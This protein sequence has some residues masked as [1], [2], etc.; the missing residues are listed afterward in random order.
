[1]QMKKIIFG[2]VLTLSTAYSLTI[3]DLREIQGVNPTPNKLNNYIILKAKESNIPPIILK[4]ILLKEGL[5]NHKWKQY[6]PDR[7]Y[8]HD[9]IVYHPDSVGSYG[10]GLFQITYFL[11]NSNQENEIKKVVRDWKFNVDMAITKLL[12]KWKANVGSTT[13]VD[14]NPLI[15]ENWYYPIAWYNGS[16]AKAKEYV[17]IVYN[18]MRD[19]NKVVYALGSSQNRNTISSYYKTISNISDPYI[20]PSFRGDDIRGS[21]PQVYTLKDIVDSGG[22]LHIWNKN[23][24]SYS[25]YNLNG[26]STNTTDGVAGIFDGAGS[27]INPKGNGYGNNYDIAK[28]YPHG[29]TGSTVVFQWLYD[30][31]TCSQLDISSQYDIGD[32]VIKSKKWSEHLTEK[33][34]KVKLNEDA[35]ITMK[36]PD[37][38]PTWITFAVTTTSTLPYPNLIKAECKTSSDRFKTGIRSDI[39]KNLVDVTYDYYWTGTGSIISNVN[40]TFNPPYGMTADLASTFRTKNSLTSF[41]WLKQGDCQKLKISASDDSSVAVNGVHIKE[42][43][44]ENWGESKCSSL[45]CTLSPSTNDFFVIK[46]KSSP[47]A[48]TSGQIQAECVQ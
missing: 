39:D 36:R 38:N 10:L 27:L 35:P 21:R 46:V 37:S 26:E 40:R 41:Q 23:S 44:A 31:S 43:D 25:R 17:D 15:I 47:D 22:E 34:F 30:A 3:D 19:I 5:P 16:G 28:M 13:G 11:D 18:Y 33:A 20:I 29:G 9:T 7:D 32:V 12:I 2:I 24:N 14:A 42:W 8:N 1:M 48:V 4:G 45:P 6:S